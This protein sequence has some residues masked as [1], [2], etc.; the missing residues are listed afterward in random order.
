[1]TALGQVF[2]FPPSVAAYVYWWPVYVNVLC[3]EC[4]NLFS[5]LEY[6]E[7]ITY[8]VINGK[9]K[10]LPFHFI[11]HIC[12]SG[13]QVYDKIA[14][15]DSI[16][17]RETVLFCYVSNVLMKK[18]YLKSWQEYGNPFSS[19]RLYL[20]FLPGQKNKACTDIASI[21]FWLFLKVP[22]YFIHYSRVTRHICHHLS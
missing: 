9:R 21:K 10:H 19:A 2:F 12:F 20:E 5:F 6:T 18:I 16:E 22:C 17:D 4:R 3:F 15:I 11:C 13:L 1:M 14:S 7:Q 8:S